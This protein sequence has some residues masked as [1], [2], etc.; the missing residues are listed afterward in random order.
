MYT[1]LQHTSLE[2]DVALMTTSIIAA[3]TPIVF[4]NIV[5]IIPVFIGLALG[6]ITGFGFLTKHSTVIQPA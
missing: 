4:I 2:T 6:V 1:K 5:G 3:I